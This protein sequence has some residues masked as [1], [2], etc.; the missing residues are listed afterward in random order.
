MRHF[1][2]RALRRLLLPRP[3]LGLPGRVLAPARPPGLIAPPRLPQRPLPRSLGARRPAVDVAPVAPP[4]NPRLPPAP[5]TQEHPRRL[6]H[7]ALP[8]R[9]TGASVPTGAM[10]QTLLQQRRLAGRGWAVGGC[11]RLPPSCSSRIRASLLLDMPRSGQTSHERANFR[12]APPMPA[13]CTLPLRS[14]SVRIEFR[15]EP[16]IGHRRR[17]GSWRGEG[18]PLRRGLSTESSSS[19]DP[20]TLE[21]D[22][23]GL[24]GAGA[25]PLRGEACCRPCVVWFPGLRVRSAR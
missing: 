7:E 23:D 2:P 6:L 4:A 11:V 8:R 12:S 19:F 17:P 13:V 18:I 5:A 14:G 10:L 25:V 24:V 16:G 9:G 20:P 22:L 3:I 15:R 21:V 1:F